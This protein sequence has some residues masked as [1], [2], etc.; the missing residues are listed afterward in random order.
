MGGSFWSRRG[1]LSVNFMCGRLKIIW[2]IES[3][4]GKISCY[5]ISW[6]MW[7]CCWSGS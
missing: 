6:S 1:M 7:V 4:R 5:F 3:W 2:N